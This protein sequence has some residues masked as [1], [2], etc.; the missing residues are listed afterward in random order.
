[1]VDSV[2]TIAE[3]QALLADNTSGDISPQDIRDMLA[4]L[5]SLDTDRSG[6]TAGGWQDMVGAFI[7]G[8]APATNPPTL[9][10]WGT[11][12]IYQWSFAATD[13][14]FLTFHVPHTY[15]VGSEFIPHVHFSPSTAMADTETI[16]WKVEWM[17]A[18]LNTDT[19][20]AFDPA[21]TVT[22]TITYT[23][24]GAV[25]ANSHLSG[26]AAG[27]VL[28]DG[29]PGTIIVARVYRDTG[30][31]LDPVWGLA[32]NGHYQSDRL[33]TL[34]PEYPFYS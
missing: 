14:I 8:T 7:A 22:T 3:M 1:M 4:T 26:D 20:V 29:A 23:A 24:S 31:Y 25:A 28:T 6:F 18:P 21:S 19:P 16:V 30:T 12:G 15:K 17:F 27:V 11:S 34:N 2:R 32:L 13:Q 10:Q 5:C 33:G 9:T